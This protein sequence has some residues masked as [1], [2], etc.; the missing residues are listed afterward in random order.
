MEKGSV[1]S[2]LSGTFSSFLLHRQSIGSR[3]VMD[4]VENRNVSV[5]S[6]WT[7]CEGHVCVSGLGVVQKRNVCLR[8]GHVARGMCLCLRSGAVQNRNVCMSSV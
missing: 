1:A 6:V 3:T 7:W 5:S 4:V 8:S 2:L